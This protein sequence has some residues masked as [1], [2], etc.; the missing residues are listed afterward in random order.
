MDVSTLSIAAHGLSELCLAV[1]MSAMNGEIMGAVRAATKSGQNGA[2]AGHA[3]MAQPYYKNWSRAQ[4]NNTEYAPMLALLCLVVKYKADKEGR[5]LRITA[6]LACVGSVFFSYLFVYAAA[7][8]GKIKH[9]RMRPG[10]G[11]MSPLRPIG[12]LGRYISMA[13]LI[14]E[15]CR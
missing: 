2:K 5:P 15:C 12:A 7:T 14:M 8:Q 1:R 9:A 11:G 6:K 10:Q 13:L 4:L 3:F